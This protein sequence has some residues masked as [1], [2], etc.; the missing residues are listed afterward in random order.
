MDIAQAVARRASVRAFLPRDVPRATLRALLEGA[1]QAPSGGNLQ[2]WRVHVLTGTALAALQQRVRQAI[3][4]GPPQTPEYPVYPERLW[5]PYRQRRRAAGAERFAALGVAD[6]DPGAQRE[7]LLRNAAFFGAPVG[8]FFCVDR[9]FAAPQW[10]DL[11]M[12]MQTLMLLAVAQGL[13]TCPQEV[14]S[15]W[16]DTLRAHLGLD[17]DHMVFAGMSLGYRD[18]DSPLNAFRTGR[19]PVDSF[20]TWHGCTG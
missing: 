2:P 5:E 4:E 11:G 20:V 18:P 12:Y 8:L 7:M 9:R 17:D 14:W 16:P 15:N 10:S 3:V 13:D 1:A 6:K 19:A